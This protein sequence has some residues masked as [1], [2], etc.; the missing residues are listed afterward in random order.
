MAKPSWFDSSNQLR[1]ISQQPM[2]S[3]LHPILGNT[4]NLYRTRCLWLL[5]FIQDMG[6]LMRNSS[7]IYLY[8]LSCYAS[9]RDVVFLIK[10]DNR[11]HRDNHI[12]S[13][14]DCKTGEFMRLACLFFICITLQASMSQDGSADIDIS[15]TSFSLDVDSL[16]SIDGFL[17]RHLAA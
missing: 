4:G 17:Y 3:H 8:G 5:S 10:A 9:I 12:Q 13:D 6:T 7:Q 2:T 15:N 1:E 14:D 16:S 11:R